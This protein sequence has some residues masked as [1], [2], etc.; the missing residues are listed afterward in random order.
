[1]T[2]LPSDIPNTR[3]LYDDYFQFSV[4][5]ANVDD[6]PA[7]ELFVGFG[8]LWVF[9]DLENDWA[10]LR[11]EELGSS[12]V[13]MCKGD[14][15]GALA[16]SHDEV[17]VMWNPKEVLHYQVYDGVEP[18]FAGGGRVLRPTL[19]DRQRSEVELRQGFCVAA[20]IDRD[21]AQEVAILGGDAVTWQLMIMDDA[22]TNY[23]TFDSFRSS[24]G[25]RDVMLAAADIDGDGFDEL[26]AEWW[27]FDGLE[28][29]KS[30]ADDT[31][32]TNE[33]LEAPKGVTRTA[34]QLETAYQMRSGRVAPDYGYPPIANVEQFVAID[35]SGRL[36]YYARNPTKNNEFAWV[37][38]R[39]PDNG[40]RSGDVLAIGNVDIDSPVVRY[41]GD[42]EVLYSNPEL[43]VALAAAPF[44]ADTNQAE[45]SSTSFGRG[46]AQS[47]DEE[48]SVGFSVGFSFGYESEDP[49]GIAKSSFSVSV[50]AAFDSL[51]QS[52]STVSEFVTYSGGPEDSVVFTV[53][54]FDVYYYE[55]VSAPDP[56][57]IGN[58]LSI[59]LP[60]T[61]QT[62]LASSAYFDQFVDDS[63]KSAPLFAT[64]RVGDPRSYSDI[65]Q[66]DVLCGGQ[67]FKASK[68]ITI[69]QGSG[70]TSVE[71]SKADRKG[72]GASYTLST[73]IASEASL[74]GVSVGASVG[75]SYGYSMTTTT[76][77]STV[78]TG[79]LGSLEDL[80]PEKSY[81]A[82]IFA[83][84]HLHPT[85]SKPVLIVDYWVE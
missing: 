14:F 15:D 58:T 13:S 20:D 38:L 17:M 51:A 7:D 85:S 27:L 74:G 23:R 76:E 36:V 4:T 81:S 54:P 39:A 46:S 21:A 40:N 33:E 44:Y 10:E 34:H 67:C 31:E 55:V 78:F 6:D 30:S 66:R 65:G 24:F 49:F 60:R 32:V 82:G 84:Q 41:T 69:G 62:L 53:V 22:N 57:E 77:E 9:D 59:N 16:D 25:D 45:S 56:A 12:I 8:D 64:H 19:N 35:G 73:E 43:L 47:V 52:G 83:H 50:N 26:I 5:A 80:T 18:S 37:E 75:F 63:R 28:N 2:Q 68:A 42:H 1:M 29:L 70:S 79:Q 48:S 61:P 72:S 11:H 3:R 71:I